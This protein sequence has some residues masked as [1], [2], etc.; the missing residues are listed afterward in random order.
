MFRAFFGVVFY[1]DLF[2]LIVGDLEVLLFFQK[3]GR[4]GGP[5]VASS[6]WLKSRLLGFLGSAMVGAN[7]SFELI[8][9]ALDKL[10]SARVGPAD[11]GADGFGDAVASFEEAGVEA[12]AD[13]A[14]VAP[15]RRTGVIRE[16]LHKVS[17]GGP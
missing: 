1:T 13:S 6:S 15:V 12:Y 10:S 8:L 11:H 5:F 14:V 4:R 3:M 16:P 9:I 2:D 7:I 17:C